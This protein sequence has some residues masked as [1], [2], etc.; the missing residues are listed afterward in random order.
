MRETSNED[1]N[2]AAN[3]LPEASNLDGEMLEGDEIL[4]RF[5]DVTSAPAKAAKDYRSWMLEHMKI[6]ICAA[7]D[8]ANGLAS[9]T[10]LVVHPD[11]REQGS[12]SYFESTEKTVPALAKVA[13]EYRAKAFE[14]MTANISATLEYAQR[15]VNVKTPTEFVELSTS[16]ARKQ[17]ELILKQTAELVSIA[18]RLATSNVERMT[19]GFAKALGEHKE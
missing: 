14:L 12:N 15:L 16:H 7:L 4:Q 2:V 17:S 10:D 19:A 11:T 9:V 3:G 1:Q 6:N 13:G 8:Y 5:E 18:Q